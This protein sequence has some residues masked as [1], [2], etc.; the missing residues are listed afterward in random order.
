[1]V[2][3]ALPLL[4]MLGCCTPAQAPAAR[5]IGEVLALGGVVG[6][7][8]SAVASHLTDHTGEFIAGF[9]VI[10]AV[11]IGMY[12]AGD[13]AGP[14]GRSETPRERNHRWAKIL[15]ARAAGAARDGRCARVRR[16]EVRVL[17]YD[18]EVHDFVFMRDPEIV[19]CMVDHR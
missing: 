13:L 12:A 18:Q 8:G 17:T 11:G 2:R 14:S 7:I 6:L 10:S 19:K 3:I 5:K 4:L 15:T 9:S 1:M 16:L